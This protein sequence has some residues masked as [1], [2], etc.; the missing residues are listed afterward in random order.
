MSL[1]ND[2]TKNECLQEICKHLG[3]IANYFDGL[4]KRYQNHQ[5]EVMKNLYGLRKGYLE[6]EKDV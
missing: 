6:K 2:P 1:S 4:D 5:E 3:R